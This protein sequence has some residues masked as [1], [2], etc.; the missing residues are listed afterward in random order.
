MNCKKLWCTVLGLN[1]CRLTIARDTSW[2]TAVTRSVS[3]SPG[4]QL[5]SHASGVVPRLGP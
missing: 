3:S 2:I 1:H 4:C 5:V